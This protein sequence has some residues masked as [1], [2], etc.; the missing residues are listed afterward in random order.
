MQKQAEGIWLHPSALAYPRLQVLPHRLSVGP[1]PQAQRH[2]HLPQE[3]VPPQGLGVPHGQVQGPAAQLSN[4][5]FILRDER[6]ASGERM[7]FD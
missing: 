2:L 5:H 4:A 6:Q 3:H 7:V 1:V